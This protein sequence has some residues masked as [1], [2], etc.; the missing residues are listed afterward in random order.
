MS[1]FEVLQSETSRFLVDIGDL[2]VSTFTDDLGV[3][4]TWLSWTN[5]R[6]FVSSIGE[7]L[8]PAQVPAFPNQ[9]VWFSAFLAVF[10]PFIF[11]RVVILTCTPSARLCG[12]AQSS[13]GAMANIHRRRCNMEAARWFRQA[14]YDLKAARRDAAEDGQAF[15]WACFK[16]RQ[17]R[18]QRYNDGAIR[19][20]LGE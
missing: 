3:S 1:V 8:P 16:C 13:E 14:E 11:L 12:D 18:S 4:V 10:I 6:T 20:G 19:S 7:M 2:F 17:V 9:V 5:I 15:E